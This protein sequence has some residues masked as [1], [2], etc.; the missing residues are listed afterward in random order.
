MDL[1]VL[2]GGV[3]PP[4]PGANVLV[5]GWERVGGERD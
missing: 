5:G 1:D 2:S 4:K 3:N